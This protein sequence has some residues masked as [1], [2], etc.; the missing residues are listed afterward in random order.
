MVELAARA[1][2]PTGVLLLEGSVR[3]SSG[4][5]W[6]HQFGNA[7]RVEGERLVVRRHALGD[8]RVEA[9]DPHALG[10]ESVV[11]TM[12][13]ATDPLR[14]PGTVYRAAWRRPGR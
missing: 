12:L 9:L 1:L 8:E 5:A 13:D 14:E 7:V 10:L 11:L 2:A 3:S 6:R 4:E